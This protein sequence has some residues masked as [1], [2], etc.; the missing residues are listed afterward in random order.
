MDQPYRIM[1]EWEPQQAVLLAWPHQS[2]DWSPW[3]ESIEQDYIKLKAAISLAAT[4]IILCRDEDHRTHISR[5]IEG[6]ICI[7]PPKLVV[8][9]YNDTWCRDYGPISLSQNGKL[10]LLD[11][12][13]RGWGDKYE[14]SLDNSINEQLSSLWEAPLKTIDFELEGGSIETDGEGTMLT[15]TRCLL[16]SD[17]NKGFGKDQIEIFLQETLGVDRILWLSEGM[18]IGDD[19]DSHIDNLARFAGPET[20][21]YLS[22]SRKTDPHFQPLKAME[23]QLREF[24]K[25][26][27]QSYQ[28]VPIEL[29]EPQIDEN[30][31]RLPASYANFLI[32]N[33][34]VI[35]PV[36]NCPQDAA[37]I[38]RIEKCFSQKR[39]VTVPGNNLIR[40]FGGP[41]CATMQLPANSLKSAL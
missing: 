24:R 30:G 11:F 19:T 25:A 4:P 23:E 39:V 29:P 35:V 6:I 5:L 12:Q 13:F 27:G 18:L 9:P 32:L 40:Q 37:A 20:I 31:A 3:L 1:A 15:T 8:A 21:V 33:G 7:N 26:D 14:A 28:L 10:Q 16:E 22:C 17:R 2:T 34:I 36:F 41:H 38:S